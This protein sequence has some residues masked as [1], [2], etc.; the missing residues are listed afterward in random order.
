MTEIPKEDRTPQRW[1]EECLKL[2]RS[3]HEG[4]ETNDEFALPKIDYVRKTEHGIFVSQNF[5]VQEPTDFYAMC[6]SVSLVY[7][8]QRLRKNSVFS[9]GARF[10]LDRELPWAFEHDL[11]RARKARDPNLQM[12]EGLWSANAWR[13]GAMKLVGQSMGYAE[14]YLLPHYTQRFAS[15]AHDYQRIIEH[16]RRLLVGYQPRRKALSPEA[17]VGLVAH[18]LRAPEGEIRDFLF[19]F[20]DLRAREITMPSDEMKQVTAEVRTE[21]IAVANLDEIAD[22]REQLEEVPAT[23]AL[24]RS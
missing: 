21:A 19:Q 20:E 18:K 4:Y 14:D 12:P 22:F 3:T 5:E 6:F 10:D 1:R 8:S 17:R 15:Q 23:L 13:R 9:L 16:A 2:A 11:G 7:P 24:L